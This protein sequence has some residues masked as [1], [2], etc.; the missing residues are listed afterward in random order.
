MRLNQAVLFSNRPLRLPVQ[1][2]DHRSLRWGEEHWSEY[3]PDPCHTH[4]QVPSGIP[5]GLR[6]R[7]LC[8]WT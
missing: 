3:K 5:C 4:R 7:C 1:T 2:Q 8:R 6:I